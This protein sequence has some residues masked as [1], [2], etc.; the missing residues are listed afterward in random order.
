MVFE[1]ELGA[2]LS[3]HPATSQ[4]CAAVIWASFSFLFEVSVFFKGW[5]DFDN[6]AKAP[7]LYSHTQRLHCPCTQCALNKTPDQMQQ[8]SLA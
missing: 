7:L 3:S 5:F 1:V 6:D 4:E 8:P 2:A